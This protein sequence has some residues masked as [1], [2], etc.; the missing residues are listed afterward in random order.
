MKKIIL[1]I[2]GMSFSCLTLGCSKVNIQNNH[3]NNPV[4]VPLIP[5]EF[6]G[7]WV[8]D[9][10]SC[11]EVFGDNQINIL[12]NQIVFKTKIAIPTE[13]QL[14]GRALNINAKIETK[15]GVKNENFKIILSENG[16]SLV[17]SDGFERFRC[18]SK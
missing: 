3:E 1:L 2:I 9:P 17:A 18:I 15:S 12:E 5:D 16:K 6:Q 7:E 14:A 11:S 4:Y 8:T 13:L 10:A